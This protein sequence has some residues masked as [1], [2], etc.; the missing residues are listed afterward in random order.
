MVFSD[1]QS[2][3]E[4][5]KSENEYTSVVRYDSTEKSDYT[6]VY[7]AAHKNPDQMST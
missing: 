3:Y 7:S 4:S 6:T 2:N 5:G 1:V